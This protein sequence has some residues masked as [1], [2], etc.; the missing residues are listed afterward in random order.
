MTGH[1]IELD[2]GCSSLVGKIDS[3]R[4]LFQLSHLQRLDLSSNNFSHSHISPE[5]GRFLNLTYL[6]LSDSYFSG[7]IPSEISHLSML[8]SL[9]FSGEM[10]KFGPHD[11]ELLLQNLTQ[12]RE[13]HLTSINISS[14]IPPIFSSHLTTLRLRD[15]GLYGIIPESIFQL[16]NLKTLIL[17][18][19]DQLSGYFPK[20]KWNSSAS[21][22][23]LDLSGVNLSCNLPD[24]LS[25]LTSLQS[26]S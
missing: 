18:N 3:N 2:L 17:Q 11:F 26:V 13:L 5:F 4:S 25:Y 8:Q 15:T 24:S 21:L 22:V 14:T 7:Q 10:L 1:V 6:D 23:E 12:L 16:P 19:N 9:Y 20:T